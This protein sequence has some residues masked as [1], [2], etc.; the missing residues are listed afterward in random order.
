MGQGAQ[1][2][3]HIE[4]M[5][6]IDAVDHHPAKQQHPRRRRSQV[7]K[8]VPQFTAVILH[9]L[10]RTTDVDCAGF[11]RIVIGR[12][13]TQAVLYCPLTLEKG[14]RLP[15]GADK[16]FGKIFAVLALAD[17][18]SQVG[19]HRLG[20]TAFALGARLVGIVQPHGAAG[21]G[22]GAA[23]LAGFLQHQHRQPFTAGGDRGGKTGRAAAD[24]DHIPALHAAAPCACG[25]A[26]INWPISLICASAISGPVCTLQPRAAA[27]VSNGVI[28]G[29]VTTSAT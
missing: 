14:Q 8:R 16:R 23:E 11:I 2:A 6:N 3:T 5:L 20:A 1:R 28:T 21:D 22:R 18:G 25:M 10:Q 24:D 12:E 7:A 9:H 4:K 13:R 29:A 17:N 26:P 27:K 19:F 15:P